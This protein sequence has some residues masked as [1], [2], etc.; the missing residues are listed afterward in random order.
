MPNYV[1]N[2]RMS[3]G[4]FIVRLAREVSFYMMDGK[5]RLAAE[6][7]PCEQHG[8]V[9]AC[10]PVEGTAMLR[11]FGVT[12]RIFE[13]E[14]ADGHRADYIEEGGKLVALRRDYRVK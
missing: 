11:G 2:A 3:T 6:Q 8:P 14:F 13:T 5:K 10:R 4:E 1:M 12:M 9:V 7:T